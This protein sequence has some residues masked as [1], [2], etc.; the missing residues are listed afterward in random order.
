MK[1]AFFLCVVVFFSFLSCR[2]DE[3]SVQQID[4]IVHMYI[5]SANHD[6]LNSRIKNSYQTV[7]MNDVYG[8]TDTAPV[9]FTLKKTEDTV[10]Y[11]EYVAG[12]KRIRIDSSGTTKIY[13]SKIALKMTKKINDS[14]NAVT[15]DTMTVDY[16]WT[17][18]FFQV[19]KIWYN[20]TLKLTKADGQ[21]NVVKIS[22]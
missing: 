13:Q 10:N 14:T 11:I 7:Q 18:E 3:T 15:N 5:D 1:S 16:L 8:L 22:K 9:N 2:N 12:A 20:N 17:P 4:Q 19:S 21:P 6:M